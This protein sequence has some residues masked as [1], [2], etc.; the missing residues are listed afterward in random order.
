[1]ASL[2]YSM[3]VGVRLG[4][5]PLM[6]TRRG[7]DNLPWKTDREGRAYSTNIASQDKG[8]GAK[9]RLIFACPDWPSCSR[10]SCHDNR[11]YH[12]HQG[13]LENPHVTSDD[14]QS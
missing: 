9:C 3:A 10:A 11:T 6:R 2:N 7:G 13:G 4:E 12:C 1:M 5:Y 8:E 14:S